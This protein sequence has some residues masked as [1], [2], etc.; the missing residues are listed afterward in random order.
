MMIALIFDTETSGLV[1]N[2][3]LRLD[4]QPE[5]IEFTGMLT[6]LKTGRVKKKLDQLIRPKNSLSEEI[7]KITGLTD[8]KLKDA[9]AFI[10]VAQN[11]SSMIESAPL[12][13]AHNATFDRDMVDIEFDRLGKK[14]S[15]PKV[16]C[17]VEQT[18]HF[19][20][21]RLS[22]TDL[23]LHLFEEPFEGAHRAASDVK[24]LL[25]CCCKLYEMG[26]L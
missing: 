16:V 26:C 1:S 8:E 13:I 23:H 10:D 2:R 25:K 24:A 4:R 7:I 11:I 22:L 5:I 14:L 9:P 6:N 17:T 15:W 21:H 18:I 3:T 20:G 12:V 19:K